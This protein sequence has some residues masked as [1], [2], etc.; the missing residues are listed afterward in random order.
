MVREAVGGRWDPTSK[1]LGL[2]NFIPSPNQNSS[3]LDFSNTKF[4]EALLDIIEENCPE[5]RDFFLQYKFHFWP[6]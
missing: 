4:C 1:F 2:S 5:V 6:F 3:W